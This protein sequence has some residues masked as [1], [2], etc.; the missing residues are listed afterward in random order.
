MCGLHIIF[1]LLLFL[2]FFLVELIML[3]QQHLTYILMQSYR[4]NTVESDRQ[5]KSPPHLLRGCI[6]HV[7]MS[8]RVSEAAKSRQQM[9]S[10]PIG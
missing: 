7:C 5:N 1:I 10:A 3:S 6:V 2:F 9:P 8:H 4:S